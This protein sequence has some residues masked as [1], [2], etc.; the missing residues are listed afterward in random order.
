MADGTDHEALPER[1]PRR[2]VASWRRSEDYG[3]PLEGAQPSF[4][5]DIDTD[6][7]FSLCGREVLGELHRSLA[8][9]PISLMLTDAAGLVLERRC[10]DHG[11]LRALDAV[12]LAP[13][14]SYAEREAGTN[15]LGLALADRVATLVRAEEHYAL[16]L[17]TYTC[18]AVPVLDPVTGRL[19]GAVNLTTFSDSSSEL[20]LA[21]A[22]SAA[23]TTTALMAARSSGSAVR[24]AS[25]GEVFRVAVPRLEP[26]SGSVV[27]LSAS[28]RDA[29][30]RMRVA[31][32]DGRSVVAV[33][34]PGS[35]R[36]TALA[37]AVRQVRPRDRVLAAR[38]P[39][40]DDVG[41][42]LD[43]WSPE[44]G[45]EHTTVL[46]GEADRLPAW[47]ADRLHERF[48]DAAKGTWCLVAERFE[49]L[50][51][52]L[53]RLV[54]VVAVP[55]LRERPED[56]VPLARNLARQVRGREID[57]TTRAQQALHDH[58]WPGN[59]AELRRVVR[60]AASRTDEVDVRHLPADVLSASGHRLSRI[61]AFERDEIVRVLTG[62]G[63]TMA[64][65]ATE[66]G[67]S[68]ATIY[69]KLTQYG[70][71]LPR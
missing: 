20:L 4:C 70:I 62:P 37:Q 43:L 24:E 54:G 26:G 9:E 31:I 56:V 18:A 33:G 36:T 40:A 44:I 13:G 71:R 27:E 65:A 30:G 11:L 69:R 34:E 46:L 1:A 16:S 60:A 42:W 53:A 29:V 49:D 48:A 6:S 68:R 38:T 25:R 58:A 21:L 22:R 5:G 15:G 12:H 50:P 35:G 14:F 3:V 23:G 47:A 2:L 67:M 61:E 52:P 19:E 66:L 55:P 41:S 64:D 39:A 8:S 10:G 63:V 45:K 59:V 7:L 57:L 32:A 51:A 28:W 17:R